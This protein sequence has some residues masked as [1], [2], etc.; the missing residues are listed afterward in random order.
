M[1]NGKKLVLKEQIIYVNI[2]VWLLAPYYSVKHLVKW[3]W[4]QTGEE[5]QGICD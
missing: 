3:F 4:K 2:F 1:S 5:L